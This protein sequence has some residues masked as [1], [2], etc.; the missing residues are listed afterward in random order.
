MYWLAS[1][2][3]YANDNYAN[4]GPGN[5]D[6]GNANSNN[7][8]FNSNGNTNDNELSARALASINCGYAV[9]YCIRDNIET[10][11]CPLVIFNCL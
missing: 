9:I 1:R 6:N 10:D 3:V 2:G 5:V 4:F 11:R 8:L 7:E